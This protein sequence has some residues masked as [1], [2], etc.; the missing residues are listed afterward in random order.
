MAS[1]ESLV[2]TWMA[3]DIPKD[4]DTNT[5]HHR[6]ST[7]PT[8]TDVDAQNHANEIRDL[9]AGVL[10]GHT[11]WRFYQDRHVDVKVYDLADAKPR[12]VKGH[13]F[14][15]TT[16]NPRASLGPRQV[17]LVLSYYSDR[18][19]KGQRGHI[20][21]GPFPHV[22]LDGPTIGNTELLSGAL[23]LGHG[24]FD[25]GGENVAHVVHSEWEN[26]VKRADPVDFVVHH[27]WVDN[28][29]DTVR[30]RG[31]KASA[32]TSLTP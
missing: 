10:P 8:I 29:W 21:L 27:Y 24:L 12:P 17:A 16:A 26:K 23:D 31:M 28:G 9:F 20:Y 22:F 2:T 32:R 25:I 19:I 7:I 15:T 6:I 13:A 30:R 4:F 11:G 3:D 18:N 5:V 1:I 14:T